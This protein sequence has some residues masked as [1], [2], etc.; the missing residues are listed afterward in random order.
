M[1]SFEQHITYVL[2]FTCKIIDSD[3]NAISVILRYL[4]NLFE[5]IKKFFLIT[6]LTFP[7]WGGGGWHLYISGIRI[8]ATDQGILFKLENLGQDVLFWILIHLLQE[9]TAITPEHGMCFG[10]WNSGTGS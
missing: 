7:R 5:T 3:V 2:I 4:S 9:K 10:F 8:C 6:N 1:F